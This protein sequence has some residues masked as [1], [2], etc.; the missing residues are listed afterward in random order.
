M[1]RPL[2]CAQH[3]STFAIPPRT[4]PRRIFAPPLATGSGAPP[5]RMQLVSEWIHLYA[6]LATNL[7][8]VRRAKRS[9]QAG[10]SSL[11]LFNRLYGWCLVIHK[12]KVLETRLLNLVHEY[13]RGSGIH[14][15]HSQSIIMMM[16]FDD[17]NRSSP[18]PSSVALCI[19]AYC[20]L[21]N[22]AYVAF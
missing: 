19:H 12:A 3:D 2:E 1:V 6:V 4:L 13:T 18:L 14:I 9:P 20:C 7:L 11:I 10:R 5:C 22:T 15:F 21:C 8:L 16:T 17:T